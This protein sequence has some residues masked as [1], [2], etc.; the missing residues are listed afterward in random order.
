M[1]IL[2][3]NHV[4][5]SFGAADIFSGITVNLQNDGKVG[6]VGPNGIGKTTLLQILAGKSSPSSGTVHLAKG[7]RIGYLT[8]ESSRAFAETARGDNGRIHTVYQEM[9]TIFAAVIADGERLAQMEAAMADNATANADFEAYSKLQQRFER[10]GGYD[11]DVH[12][13]RTLDGL[14]FAENE[15]EM[16]INHLSGGQKTRLLL[17]KLLLE[18]PNLL[19]MDEPTN[20]LDMEAV[21]WLEGT[22]KTWDGA[23]LI[24]SHDRYFL[25]KVVNTIWEMSQTGIEQYRSN[26][27]AYVHQREERWERKLIEYKELRERLD[28]E[29]DYIRR[30]MAGQR[31]QMAQGKLSR[32]SREVEAI[33]AGGLNAIHLIK[34]KGWLQAKSLLSGMKSPA[35]RT[36]DLQK[37]INALPS[38]TPPTTLRLQ[39]K[40]SHRSGRQVL[41]SK[42]LTIGYPNAPLFT[43]DDINLTLGDCAALIGA[44]GVGKTTLL[45]TILKQIDP[46]EGELRHGASLQIGYFSQA[47]D[48]LNDENSVL[49]EMLANSSMLISEARNYLGRFLFRGD[50]VHKRVK[51]L[52]GGERGRLA[53]A[54][55]TLQ[56]ANFLLLDEPTNHLDIP[57]QEALQAALEQYD[58][59]IL[60]VSHDRYLVDRLAAQIWDL[61]DGRLHTFPLNYQEFLAQRER[62]RA[63]EKVEKQKTAVPPAPVTPPKKQLSKNEQRKRAEALHQIEMAIAEAES[64]LAAIT[65]EIERATQS[66]TFD[67]IQSLSV[68][69]AEVDG[70]LEEMMKQWENFSDE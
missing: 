51:S 37:R 41:R 14:G 32:L 69:Y 10:A 42:K 4:A 26:Y 6:L 17:A 46:L 45:R 55:L 8:Q 48:D 5:Q 60:L 53:L 62:E 16:D 54:F 43:A 25:D 65:K 31:T 57:S 50:D 33:H 30:N 52:S 66:Q 59:T 64:R 61:R 20:H 7:T 35:D 58:G 44:N 68:K 70:E 9:L 18:R 29:M 63:K 3:A 47:R 36:G 28:K 13:R 21:E 19:I 24:V 22:L 11:Y 12:I 39:L 38:P 2:S 1:A 67:K 23:V 34:S 40:A 56:K 49:E 27:S 15:W